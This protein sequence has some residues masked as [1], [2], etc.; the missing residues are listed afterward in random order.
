MHNVPVYSHTRICTFRGIEYNR[1][2]ESVQYAPIRLIPTSFSILARVATVSDWKERWYMLRLG[3]KY[4]S[5]DGEWVYHSLSTDTIFLNHYPIIPIA[6]FQNQIRKK[7]IREIKTEFCQN[8]PIKLIAEVPEGVADC[9]TVR[10]SRAVVVQTK[11][12]HQEVMG[13]VVEVFNNQMCDE[14]QQRAVNDH[15]KSDLATYAASLT[16]YIFFD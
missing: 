3:P 1:T 12:V 16:H 13:D 11:G 5:Y 9:R 15:P 10:H 2:S 8:T 4:A 6:S 7:Y 14:I